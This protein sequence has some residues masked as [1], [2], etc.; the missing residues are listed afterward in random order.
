MPRQSFTTQMQRRLD[1]LDS[2]LDRLARG[3]AAKTERGRY[4][5]EKTRL[6]LLACR[7]ELRERMRAVQG[8]PEEAW[9]EL[10]ESLSSDYEGLVQSVAKALLPEGGPPKA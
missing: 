9:R 7:A 4:E 1:D 6:H 2:K 5:R 3:P 8:A 10:A